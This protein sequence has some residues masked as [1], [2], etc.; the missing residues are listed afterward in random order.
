LELCDRVAVLSKGRLLAV[1]PARALERQYSDERY[2]VRTRD[3]DHRA[4]RELER[5]G[6]IDRVVVGDVDVD[7]WTSIECHVPGGAD[8]AAEVLAV[9]AAARVSVAS[10]ERLELSLADLIERI[11]HVGSR[12]S[13]DA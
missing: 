9:L 13:P 12:E 3:A 10:F 4:W 7:G 8:E 1:G 2:R 5:R 11:V 6:A